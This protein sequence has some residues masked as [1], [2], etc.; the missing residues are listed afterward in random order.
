MTLLVIKSTSA[1]QSASVQ[2]FIITDFMTS[3]PWEW[4]DGAHGQCAHA[5]SITSKRNA[6]PVKKSAH[7]I[8]RARS[9]ETGVKRHDVFSVHD[10]FSGHMCSNHWFSTLAILFFEA[11]ATCLSPNSTTTAWLC[12]TRVC[13]IID[14]EVFIW[15]RSNQTF[16]SL[17]C[18]ACLSHQHPA[19]QIVDCQQIHL[20]VLES[21]GT[22]LETRDVVSDTRRP[23]SSGACS[24]SYH[25][26][27]VVVAVQALFQA[28]PSRLQYLNGFCRLY[29][30]H[31][32]GCFAL[33]ATA[34]D[35]S[36]PDRAPFKP[37]TSRAALTSWLRGSRLSCT[38]GLLAGSLASHWNRRPTA[39]GTSAQSR[40]PL[41]HARHRWAGEVL[42]GPPYRLLNLS[43]LRWTD[44]EI[45]PAPLPLWNTRVLDDNVRQECDTCFWQR[46]IRKLFGQGACE[47]RKWVRACG[48]WIAAYRRARKHREG[49]KPRNMR[50]NALMLGNKQHSSSRQSGEWRDIKTP[51][52]LAQG[53]W[54]ATLALDQSGQI[55]FSTEFKEVSIFALRNIDFKLTLDETGDR[56]SRTRTTRVIPL[57]LSRSCIRVRY[58][59]VSKY[60]PR[61][62]PEFS[63]LIESW[64]ATSS[65]VN[66]SSAPGASFTSTRGEACIDPD[67]WIILKPFAQGNSWYIP[68]K[69]DMA[70]L[71][72]IRLLRKTKK[73]TQP[74]DESWLFTKIKNENRT[75]YHPSQN[76]YSYTY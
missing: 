50:A 51:T 39:E 11:I 60:N 61:L 34:L 40:A 36:S 35:Q 16:S 33:W 72:R 62:S 7:Q 76:K 74:M 44:Q 12:G 3:R 10:S 63:N 65:V 43:G 29:V 64:M 8:Y 68:K 20:I 1:T 28:W 48:Q 23:I 53:S 19:W 41:T 58:G 69:T 9:D 30:P 18:Q 25:P 66:N 38:G 21:L 67:S 52:E 54:E 37:P 24:Q 26:S 55:N 56:P 17:L 13:S 22:L 32:Q 71:R 15:Q 6:L 42:Q 4:P 57:A 59:R 46:Q 27:S 14:P 2:G 75:H 73:K 5:S 45:S 31:C 49:H 47:T 70:V